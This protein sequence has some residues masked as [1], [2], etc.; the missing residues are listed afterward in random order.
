MVPIRISLR[1]DF[2]F[3]LNPAV[4]ANVFHSHPAIAQHPAD[5]Q[6]P[7]ACG[8]VFLGAQYGDIELADAPL[9]PCETP[10]KKAGRRDAVI[11]NMPF[12]IVELISLRAPAQLTPEIEI[13]NTRKSW[14][15]CL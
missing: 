11:E 5:Q 10:L 8:R 12:V 9:H 3:R 2:F 13:T 15:A 6:S 7:M 4:T 1:G 14:R